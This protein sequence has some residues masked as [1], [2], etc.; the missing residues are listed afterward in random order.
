MYIKLGTEPGGIVILVVDNAVEG[1]YMAGEVAR[2][3][4]GEDVRMYNYPN[5]DDDPSL[6]DVDGVVIG[7]SGAGVYDEPDQ[8]WITRQ[9][10]F[11]EEI[12]DEEIPLLG[13]CF[14]HQLVNEVLGGTV[15]NSGESRNYLVEA[16]LAEIPLFEGVRNVVPVLHSDIV[17]EPGEG[18]EVVGTADYNRYFATRHHERP[19]WTVQYHPEF[20][21]E[22]RPEYSDSW[23]ESE[24]SFEASTA[25]RTLENFS[26]CCQQRTSVSD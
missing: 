4:P 21:P 26:Q 16:S 19:I 25:T 2:L 7:G 14:G 15:V 8:P 1:G 5:G 20:T 6:E 13:I 9:K 22:I 10:E 11:V 18:M 17:T 24:Y 23:D 3:L 12:I